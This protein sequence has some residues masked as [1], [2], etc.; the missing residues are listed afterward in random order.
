[1]LSHATQ[2][3]VT[4][5]S[6]P[7]R[8]WPLS[9]TLLMCLCRANALLL[10]SLLTTSLR[11][12]T[13]RTSS[14]VDT[15]AVRVRVESG[16]RPVPGAQI[17]LRPLA[18]VP[19]VT[20]GMVTA[21]Q[22]GNARIVVGAGAYDIIAHKLGYVS[23]SLRVVL[24]AGGDTTVELALA[25]Q[26]LQGVVVTAT[27]GQRRI[28]DEPTRVEVLDREEVEEQTSMNPGN[29]S[30]F[31]S[32]TGGVRVATTSPSL[33]GANVRVL[34]LRGRYTELLSDGLPLYGL[35]TEG[36]GLLQIPPV[37]LRQVELIKGA[38]SALYG[39]T[40]LAGVVNFVSRRPPAKQ[41]TSDLF[42]NQ[43][44][45]DATDA[46]LFTG[47]PLSNSWGY[48]LL[49]N[50]DRQRRQDVNGDGW[51]DIA[52]YDR[53]L[54]RPRLF[55]TSESGSS[56]FLTS[57]FTAENRDGGTIAGA[58]LPNG[59]TFAEF[60]DTRRGDIGAVSHVVLS[61]GL[62]LD[63]RASTTEEWHTQG[64]GLDIEHDRRTTL[65][66]E[67]ALNAIR[68]SHD[69]VVGVALEGDALSVQEAPLLQYR[70]LTPAVFLQDTWI[71]AS[72]IGIA[73]GA[74]VD[75][76]SKY[77]TLVSP[78]LSVR[79]KLPSE[80]SARFSGGEG[81][82]TAT[83]FVEE[84]EEIGLLRLRP[85]RG[86]A[87]ERGVGGS[88]DVGGML[89]A[90]EINVSVHG[91]SID[92]AVGIRPAAG[93]PVA[94]DSVELINASIPT[95]IEGGEFFARYRLGHYSVTG[96]YAYLHATE[97]DLESASSILDRRN[98]PLT[99]RH[100]AGAIASWEPKDD[101]GLAL[102]AFYTGRQP[103]SDDPYRTESLPYVMVGA[104]A[105]WRL[106]HA[107]AF[108]NGENLGNV[109]ETRYEPLLRPSPGLGGRWTV[110]AW[111][112]LDGAVVNAGIRL[113]F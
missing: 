86:L 108:V 10:A 47:A 15:A 29:V 36:L 46:V 94:S 98:V 7:G 30:G 60:R 80:W 41:A 84:T 54:V 113:T 97:Q 22:S 34:G 102:E 87:S 31:L 18:R 70:F 32:E 13:P 57:G 105:Q 88:A 90:I 111:A 12:Q 45:R 106:G 107:V 43:T 62:A 96:T 2:H 53:G 24:L 83:P 104:L 26:S 109:Q 63:V 23:A 27:R 14:S 28:E 49:A 55:G 79:F 5:D 17:I 67:A 71:P 21:D 50:A 52:G 59:E 76:H 74:R 42:I 110:D 73:G 4:S 82:Y 75:Q 58:A 25:R 1:M 40:A 100:A 78:R 44:S 61:D 66:G 103:L 72:W 11:G 38:A 3:G 92:R 8:I 68:G 48:T 9:T 6:R 33:G 95:R 39:P 16:E 77:G 93:A 81:A 101:T 99:P 69:L 35:S 51:A 19:G 64:F 91:S 89:G 85:L 20:D 56:F 65:F 112:P 37:D